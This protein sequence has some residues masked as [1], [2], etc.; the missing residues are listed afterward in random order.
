MVARTE[1]HFLDESTFDFG[2][3]EAV[4]L[5]ELFVRAYPSPQTAEMILATSGIDRGH[6]VLH[7]PIRS[8][9]LSALE[10]AARSG[11][12][13]TLVKR[14]RADG[15]VAAYFRDLDRLMGPTPSLHE[16]TPYTASHGQWNGR[17]L[18]T[19][20]QESFLEMSFFRG[21]LRA[22]ASV[23]RLTVSK[24]TGTFYGSGFLIA[25]STLLTNHHV[26]YDED[27]LPA[28]RVDAWFN[29]ELDESG[30][31]RQ[32]EFYE[33]ETASIQGDATYDWA[34]LKTRTPVSAG[35]PPLRLRPSRPVA[36]GDFVYIIQHPEGRTKKI[37]MHHNQVVRVTPDIVQYLTDTLPGSSGAPVCNER[38][39][40]VAL[41]CRG[42]AP[43]SPGEGAKNEGVHIDRVIQALR[44][45][46]IEV[47]YT[48]G[49]TGETTPAGEA[50]QRPEP[51]ATSPSVQIAHAVGKGTAIVDFH[52]GSHS[53]LNFGGGK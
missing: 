37:G 13:R 29:Y 7:Q 50:S 16:A 30:A 26:L 40:V 3:P 27:G 33:G 23:A 45:R 46:G 43:E 6:L 34:I 41:H 15:S 39:E 17:E 22:A 12:T 51:K 31:P 11:K 32:V 21:A 28:H 8:L 53:T 35:A 5:Y 1:I 38:W 19:G 18:V 36:E 44:E 49:G 24:R 9:W 20:A 52:V 48:G 14:A 42:V 10:S 2:K 4:E 25:P 47:G